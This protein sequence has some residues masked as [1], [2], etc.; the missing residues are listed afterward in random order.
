MEEGGLVLKAKDER[1]IEVLIRVAAGLLSATEAAGLLGVSDRQARR[2]AAAY[3]SEGPRG[4][5]HGNRG[6]PP[7][8]T[9]PKELRDQVRAL[10]TGR[11]AGVNHSHLAELLAEREGIQIARSTL[12]DILREAGVRSPR[13]QKRRSRHRSRR[14]RYPQEGMLLQ[15]DAS[16]HDWLQGRGPRLALLAVIDDATGKVAG[17]RFHETEDAR[18]YLL[19]LRDVCR[20]VGIPHAIYSDKHAVFW[21]TRSETLQE[22]LAGRRSPTQFGRAMAELGIQ[23]IA[24]HSPQAKGR[25]ERLWGTLQDRLV[26]ELR[27][28]N[29]ASMREANAFLPSFLARCNRSFAVIP[30]SPGSAYRQRLGAAELDRTLCFKHERVVGKDNIVRLDQ[31]VLQ[32]LPGPSRLG[33]ARATVVIHE[34]L[35]HRFSVHFGGR[36]LPAKLLPLRKLLTPKRPLRRAPSPTDTPTQPTLLWKPPPDHPWRNSALRTKSLGT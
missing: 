23:L 30:E 19:L 20:K 5:V 8:H 2:L 21:P 11:Y 14:E 16:H 33:Y 4:V 18:G 31:V 3:R 15:I 34:S 22:Q 12:T 7:A 1:R 29:V 13:P 27:L 9:L 17:A 36:Q 32:I 35:D 10:A 24:A 26:S 6:R 28:A 25:I